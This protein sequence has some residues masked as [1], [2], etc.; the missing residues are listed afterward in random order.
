MNAMVLVRATMAADWQ[1]L[2]DIRLAALRDAPDA[3][4][5]SYAEDAAVTEAQWRERAGGHWTMFLAFVPGLVAPR[6]GEEQADEEQPAGMAGCFPAGAGSVH[7]VA[8]FVRPAGR[9][10]GVGEAL[11]D[12]VLGWARA[13]D[14]ASVD[15][16]VT[17][18][19]K[20]ARR[21]Y[22]RCGFT[23]TGARQPLPSNPAL[24][25]IALSRTP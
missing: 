2:R 8:M 18:A 22:E 6:P 7:V 23:P 13:H 20:P 10:L 11:I 15:L 24:T 14:A 19:N 16:W 3:F 5:V 25:E 4:A 12:A 17:E 21:L 9:G 1:I